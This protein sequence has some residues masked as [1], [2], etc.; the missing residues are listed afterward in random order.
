MYECRACHKEYEDEDKAKEC[1]TNDIYD[2]DGELYRLSRKSGSGRPYLK[3]HYCS[4]VTHGNRRWSIMLKVEEKCP[5]CD[6]TYRP[7]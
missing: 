6:Y 3:G 1:C 7:R 4:N 2:E 5:M